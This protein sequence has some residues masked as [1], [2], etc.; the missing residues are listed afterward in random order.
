VDADGSYI[1]YHPAGSWGASP[2]PDHTLTKFIAP[3]QSFIVEKNTGNTEDELVFNT[4]ITELA[5]GSGTLKAAQSIT[6]KLEITATNPAASFVTFIANRDNSQDASRMSA[7][8][9]NIPDI[10][11]LK[12]TKALGANIIQT[13]DILIPLGISTAYAGNMTLT[14]KGMDSYNAK[15]TLID[16]EK[17]GNKEIELTGSELVYSFEYTPATNASGDIVANNTRFAIQLAPNAP[18]SI[19]KV[20]ESK[21][22]VYS[23][24]QS[25]RVQG[26]SASDVIKGIYVYDAQGR[27]VYANDKVNATAYTINQPFAASVYV[28]KVV[29]ENGVKNVKVIN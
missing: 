23:K 2:L 21:V 15:I 13:D 8:I 3:F 16:N 10:Y 25:I 19:N 18:T 12:G 28:V 1:G 5:T 9:S 17:E 7:G 6:D 29:T 26:S 4:S 11:T 20:A 22:S 24:N 14:F 27:V